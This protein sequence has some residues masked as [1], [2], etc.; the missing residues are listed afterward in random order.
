MPNTSQ[1]PEV[2]KKRVI[3]VGSF[4][5]Y[6]SDFFYFYISISYIYISNYIYI[7]IYIL[8]CIYIYERES[9]RGA[10]GKN[11]ISVQVDIDDHRAS[12]HSR[13]DRKLDLVS[14]NSVDSQLNG[15]LTEVTIGYEP[16]LL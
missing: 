15:T 7:I 13:V 9:H 14:L 4:L 11:T 3:H 12:H 6:F 8:M 2:G 10:P 16:Q 5:I 1:F